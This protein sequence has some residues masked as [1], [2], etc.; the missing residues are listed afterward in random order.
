MVA[1][2]T[3]FSLIKTHLFEY[4]DEEFRTRA[5]IKTVEPITDV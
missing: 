3:S 5:V 4:T 2:L 1:L